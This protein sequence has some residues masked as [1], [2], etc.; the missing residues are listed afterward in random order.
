VKIIEINPKIKALVDANGG[1]CPCAATKSHYT[2]CMCDA[3]RNQ[4]IVGQCH[5][6]RYEKVLDQSDVAC[7][8]TTIESKLEDEPSRGRL[9]IPRPLIV[10]S[11]AALRMAMKLMKEN[12]ALQEGYDAMARDLETRTRQVRELQEV[13]PPESTIR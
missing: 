1:Y 8:I 7:L 13:N 6:G 9:T 3:F 4:L 2:K 5:C 11:A 12:K 10:N